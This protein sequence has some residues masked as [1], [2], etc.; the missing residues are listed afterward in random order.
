MAQ[1]GTNRPGRPRKQEAD[2]ASKGADQRS[3]V[4]VASVSKALHLLTLFTRERP[5]WNLAELVEATG[6]N[7]ASV[8]RILRTLEHDR[9]LAVD[10]ET[11]RYYLGPAMY[12][13][14]YLT[15]AHSELV[16]LSHPHLESLAK[17]TGETTA[18]GVEVGGWVVVVDHV[19][20]SH[21]SK[22]DLPMGMALNDLS[23]SHAKLFLAFKND[24]QRQRR[25]AAGWPRLTKNTVDDPEALV[26]Q[27]D[28]IRREGVAYDLE[29]NR[30]GISSMSVPVRD[31]LGQL[32]ASLA[33]VV[34]AERLRAGDMR[35]YV[36]ATQA[37]AVALSRDLG[38]DSP[39]AL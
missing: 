14:A 5:E 30:L 18:L 12:P 26:R 38:C 19:L 37:E 21:A 6:L 15:Q 3:R 33:V 10:P 20:T 27:L 13:V 36:E 1:R 34:P 35:R 7:R 22:P 16:R 28:Q 11:G 32:R 2:T 4:L 39:T 25:V 31:Q 23:N 17:T 24:A 29:E 9:F 8:Y